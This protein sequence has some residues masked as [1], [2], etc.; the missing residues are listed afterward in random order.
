MVPVTLNSV[1]TIFDEIYIHIYIVTVILK[2]DALNKVDKFGLIEA[3][4]RQGPVIGNPIL[5]SD[6]FTF[7]SL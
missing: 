2:S 5:F 1:Q 7:M 3:R 6:V 4:K